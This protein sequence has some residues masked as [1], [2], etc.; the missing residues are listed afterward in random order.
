MRIIESIS[1]MQ[2]TAESWRREGKRIALVPTMGYLHEG[3]L[4]LMRAIRN[5]G[6][7]LVTSIFVNPAQFGPGEDFERYPR[8]LER[9]QELARIGYNGYTT[10]EIAGD[11]AVKKSYAY[12]KSR[13]FP[14]RRH[15]G[16]QAVPYRQA[17]HGSFRGKGFPTTGDDPENGSGSE[18]GYRGNRP[19]HGEGSGW[20]GDEQPECLPDARTTSEGHSP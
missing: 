12:L 6:D 15:R 13:P 11:E 9:D 2:Q 20:L 4:E 19:S 1:E 5:R 16:R 18:Y 14:R 3:H 7:V 8:D 17:A 10:L